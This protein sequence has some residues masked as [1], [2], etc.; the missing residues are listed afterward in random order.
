MR[1]LARAS[2]HLLRPMALRQRREARARKD[3]RCVAAFMMTIE[4]VGD[5]IDLFLISECA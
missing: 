2:R 5:A 4:I 3:R 1:L